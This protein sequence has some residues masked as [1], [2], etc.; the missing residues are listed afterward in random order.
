MQKRKRESK[1]VNRIYMQYNYI[2]FKIIYFKIKTL[3]LLV[4]HN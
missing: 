2:N 3:N 4:S 1:L